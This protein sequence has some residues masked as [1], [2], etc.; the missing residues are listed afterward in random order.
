MTNKSNQIPKD[1]KNDSV[2]F[3]N[4]IEKKTPEGSI[5]SISKLMI[6]S[7]AIGIDELNSRLKKW[8]EKS[9]PHQLDDDYD[10]YLVQQDGPPETAPIIPFEITN[11]EHHQNEMRYIMI[12]LINETQ[13]R[14]VSTTQ[15]VRRIGDRIN[16]FTY[17]IIKPFNRNW[18]IPPLRRRYSSLIERGEN[19]LNRLTL[20][21]RS[22]YE[23]SRRMAQLA[24]EDSFEE[25]VDSLATNPEVQNLI[26]SQGMGMAEEI[27]NEVRERAISAD[28]F[29]EGIFRD[30]FRRKPRSQIPH[31]NFE[32]N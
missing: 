11:G 20:V 12:G 31:P 4:P 16:R 2:G 18:L 24:Y 28:N 3:Q 32:V 21:G 25:A 23:Q 10:S 22:E 14:L 15:K 9:Q 6:G 17:P 26:Q 13:V 30:F 29:F 1:Q 7:L 19:E 27:I 5:K 8:D